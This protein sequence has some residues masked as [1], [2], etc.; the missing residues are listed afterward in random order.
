LSA[1]E[2]NGQCKKYIDEIL[3]DFRENIY[4]RQNVRKDIKKKIFVKLFK[5][6]RQE[7]TVR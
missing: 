3:A 1:S 6:I 4:S 5:Q 2:T 7:R